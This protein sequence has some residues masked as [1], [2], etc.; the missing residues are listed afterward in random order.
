MAKNKTDLE[1]TIKEKFPC[2]KG[3]YFYPDFGIKV[4]FN[5][6][7]SRIFLSIESIEEYIKENNL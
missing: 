7:T 1:T 2:V 3:V 5:N 4:W 6:G